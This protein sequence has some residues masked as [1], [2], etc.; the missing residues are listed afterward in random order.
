MK[1]SVVIPCYNA[2]RWVEEALRSVA[3]QT[4]Q[5][6]EIIVVDDGSTD[7]SL[8]RIKASGVDVRLLHTQRANG[9]GARNVGI[10]AAT[11][12]WIAFQDADDV[13]DPCH[14]ERATALLGPSTDVAFLCHFDVIY[15]QDERTAFPVAPPRPEPASG[16]SHLDYVDRFNVGPGLY[17]C[18]PAVIMNRQRLMD[19]GLFDTTQIRR[20]DIDLWLRV[21]GGQTWSYDPAVSVAFRS[22]TGGISGHIASREYYYLRAIEKS[23][24]AYRS[25]AMDKVLTVAVSKAL[26]TAFTDGDA[27]DRRRACELAWPHV[28]VRMWV[29]F[30]FARLFP[31]LFRWINL[32]R[33]WA[34]RCLKR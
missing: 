18:H 21:I 23:L 13:W 9:A 27:D 28:S 5:P 19:V 29:L 33:R 17:Y 26:A 1:F 12:D 14:L 2:G 4:H 7:D 30:G 15:N 11:G 3:E 6:H 31:A 22:G 16:L 10:E 34:F 20:H 25:P 24:D 8:D 32:S